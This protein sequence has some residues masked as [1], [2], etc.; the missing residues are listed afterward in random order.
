MITEVKKDVAKADET[1]KGIEWVEGHMYST[2]IQNHSD[3]SLASNITRP[4]LVGAM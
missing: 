3:G 4:K 2:I 1:A